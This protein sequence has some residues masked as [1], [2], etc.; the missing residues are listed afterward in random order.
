M[1]FDHEQT[2]AK[3]LVGKDLGRSIIVSASA[4][5]GKTTVLVAR[6]VKRCLQEGIA[7]RRIMAVTFTKAA[8]AEMKRRVFTSL[9]D[10]LKEAEGEKAE[11]IRAQIADLNAADITTIDSWCLSI[12]RKYCN[13]IG[14]DPQRTR[15]IVDEGSL[16]LLHDM[17]FDEA[18][19]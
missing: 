14:L 1:P 19:E 7:I 6:I 4:G 5:A 11:Y 10:A 8:A 9:Q 2:E 13:V 12:I 17:A 16:G 15:R 18:F 3:D